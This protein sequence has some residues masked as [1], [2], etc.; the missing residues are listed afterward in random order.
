MCEPRVTESV[1]QIRRAS[2]SKLLVFLGAVTTLFFA[3]E[4]G[5]GHAAHARKLQGCTFSRALF[6]PEVKDV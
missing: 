2:E 3:F 5:N 4:I 1:R 6:S